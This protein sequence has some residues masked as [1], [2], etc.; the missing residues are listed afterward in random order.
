MILVE[1]LHLAH[2]GVD[3]VHVAVV[4]DSHGP[5]SV[6]VCFFDE[7]GDGGKAVKDGVLRGSP[8]KVPEG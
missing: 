2:K 6:V 3:A 8:T 4:G 5:L 1:F 7:F